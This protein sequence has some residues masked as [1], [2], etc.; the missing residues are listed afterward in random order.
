[1]NKGLDIRISENSDWSRTKRKYFQKLEFNNRGMGKEE[2]YVTLV[3]ASDNII[4]HYDKD[5][6]FLR[7]II[8]C[9]LFLTLA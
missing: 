1:M 7:E 3:T 4:Q 5:I 8:G 6:L 2:N 9:K